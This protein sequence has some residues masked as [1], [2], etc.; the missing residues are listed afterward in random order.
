M[1]ETEK[2]R[3]KRGLLRGV[4]SNVIVLGVVSMLTDM[5][6]EM[7]I[8]IIPFFLISI[9]ATGL[10]VG[11]VEGAAE[12][13]ASL[14]KVPA[15]WFSDKMR[16]RKPFVLG[17]YGLS[18]SVKP[19]LLAA[20]VPW[21][22]FAIRITER[23]GKGVRSAPR[24]ALIADSTDG[25]SMGR[26]YGF[27]KFMDTFGAML[28]VVGLVALAFAMGVGL[29]GD[30]G[31]EDYKVIFAVAAVP[32]IAA[33]AVIVVFV[34]EKVRA[35]TA[36]MG[37]FLA[38]MRG[39]GKGFWLL[40][41]VV[42]AFYIGEVNQAFFLLR[43]EEAGHSITTVL[44][45]YLLFNVAFALPAMAFGGMSDRRG[46]KPVIAMS[47]AIFAAACCV[48]IVAEALWELVVA[49]VLLGVYKASSEG[50]FKAYVVDSVDEEMRASA[51]GAFHT[52][53]GLVML[54]G[55]L[56]AGLLWDAVGSH[57]TFM[58]GAAMAVISIALLSV[59][60]PREEAERGG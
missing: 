41:V 23:V 53:V 21:H 38:G 57:A 37:T 33:V 56:L 60:A 14:L 22:V 3:K 31:P 59:I 19:L 36:P 42:M 47:F 13:T 5:S 32:A 49:F 46:R 50:V 1:N 54:P 15:G 34:K 10:V 18:A 8:P 24:D 30:Y 9:G 17:G 39:L 55:G 44:L 58:F 48:M 7:I 4:S 29:E 45:L 11:I 40:M 52:G 27:H 20:A 26:A 16:R 6:S 35:A 28:G 43:G 25:D 12:T 2:R 51:L